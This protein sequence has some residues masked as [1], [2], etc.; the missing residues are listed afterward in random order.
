MEIK[1]SPKEYYQERIQF[2]QEKLSQLQQLS[3]RFVALRL[4]FFLAIPF[5]IYVFFGTVYLAVIFAAMCF[6][7]FLFVVRKSIDVKAQIKFNKALVQINEDE[8]DVLAGNFSAFDNGERFKNH[9]H[10]FTYDM[11]FFGPKSIYQY[12]NRAVSV[13]GKVLLAHQLS[14]GV[15]DVEQYHEATEALLKEVTWT[16]EFRAKGK[17][18]EGKDE[19][20][21]DEW[22]KEELHLPQWVLVARIIFPVIAGLGLI[23]KIFDRIT[24]SYFMLVLL[25]CLLPVG[26]LLKRTNA[27]AGKLSKIQGRLD[28]LR[29]QL[30][31]MRELKAE[32][33]II[34]K[35]KTE[36]FDG[37]HSADKALEQLKKTLE[38][39]DLRMNFMVSII[40]NMFG[41]Y[42][43]QMMYSLSKWKKQ[44]AAHIHEWEKELLDMEV[45]IS[46]M[47]FK[48]NYQNELSYPVLDQDENAAI[49]I[50]QLGHPFLL[51]G[52]LVSN[53]FEL[54][55]SEQFVIIT[56]PNM[57]GKS[58]FLRSVG[59]NLAL[60]KAGFSVVAK[61]FK[62][63][64]LK[65]YSSMRTADN[66]TEESSYFHAELIRLRFIVDAID[67]GEKIFIVL[68]EI[69][70]GTNSKDK[71]EGSAKFL[72]KLIALNTKG[73]IA[74]HDLSLTK[75]AD[76]D[77]RIKNQYFDSIIEGDN[78]SFSYKMH[79]GVV[80]NMNASFL[81]EQMKLV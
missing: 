41:A 2:L 55:S 69:L 64:N 24:D 22:S 17:V 47:N 10:P 20:F 77:H 59:V 35:A 60:A 34:T 33:D 67:R 80:K 5:C 15:E 58:T 48:F 6:G 16:Q 54:N 39:F 29:G 21:I 76:E 19:T 81:L 8:L 53:D 71:E 62:F 45:L 73:I 50:N 37:K 30:S 36:L 78:I 9:Q 46:Q 4:I 14:E 75:L 11:D 49:H 1:V 66:L 43:L 61:E 63:P 70:K 42:D 56:G 52:A 32:S 28:A 38:R 31:L 12:L 65:L 26:L 13:K 74:T 79:H 51:S 68:D 27:E 57:A 18:D 23:A 25:L 40:F 44:Y 3:N 7:V 72:K